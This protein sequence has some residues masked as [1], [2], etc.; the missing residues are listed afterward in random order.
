MLLSSI[1]ITITIVIFLYSLIFYFNIYDVFSN[2]ISLVF[3][4]YF[5]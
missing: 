4:K 2:N 3:Y 5:L 1:I